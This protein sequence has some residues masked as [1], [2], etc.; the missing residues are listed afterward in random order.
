MRLFHGTASTALDGIEAQGL[1]AP[2]LTSSLALAEYY[3]E[4]AAEAAEE[5]GADEVNPVVLEVE[6]AEVDLSIDFCALEEPCGY[7]GLKIAVLEERV[8]EMWRREGKAHP[9]WLKD[10]VILLP[11]ERFDLSLNTVGSARCS[12]LIP[13]ANLRVVG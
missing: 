6:V 13:W 12:V 1:T 4:V 2:C 7:D 5:E 3:A 8:A 11:P 9:E 10:G